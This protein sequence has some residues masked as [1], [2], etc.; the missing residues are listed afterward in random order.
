MAFPLDFVFRFFTDSH[1]HGE[2]TIAADVVYPD[3]TERF[4]PAKLNLLA[5]IATVRVFN[6]DYDD[7]VDNYLV[8]ASINRGASLPDSVGSMND[9]KVLQFVVNDANAVGSLDVLIGYNATS[10]YSMAAEV[11]TCGVDRI[12]VRRCK[13]QY[14]RRDV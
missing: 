10:K 8:S 3:M 7:S 6:D 2:I 4:L 1:H 11:T 14:G 5:G 9:G 12:S 13:C